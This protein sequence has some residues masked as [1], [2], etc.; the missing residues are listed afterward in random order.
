MKKKKKKVFLSFF[1]QTRLLHCD[2]QALNVNLIMC[3]CACPCHIKVIKVTLTWLILFTIIG[4][5]KWKLNPIASIA[6]K[7]VVNHGATT[8]DDISYNDVLNFF[9]NKII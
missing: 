4:C 3:L 2:H 8:C 6:I 7:Q 9:K 5:Q 1:F